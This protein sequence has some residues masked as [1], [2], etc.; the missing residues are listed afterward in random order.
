MKK[1]IIVT[2]TILLSSLAAFAQKSNTALSSQIKNN[3]IKL[4]YD[5]GTGS[6]KLMAI[7]ENFPDSEAKAA[8]VMAMN[9][10]VGFFYPGD[11]LQQMPQQ[12]MLTFWIMSKK[13]QF[14]EKHSLT[15]YSGG[16]IFEIGDARYAGKPQQ[17]ME[18]LNFVISR[19]VLV[20]AVSFSDVQF[21][22]GDSNFGFTRDQLRMLADLLILSDPMNN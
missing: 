1:L 9:F 22:L 10:A 5:A 17:N 2:L 14:A 12:I 11:K 18:Y 16:E 19:D 21:K 6:S 3:K 4:T 8:K 7:A 15:I 13:P 20:K